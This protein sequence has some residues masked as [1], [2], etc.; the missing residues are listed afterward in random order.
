[1]HYHGLSLRKR[2]ALE[3]ERRLN[4]DLARKHPLRQLFWECTLRCDLKCRHCGSDCKMKSDS[5]D[6]PFEDFARVLESVRRRTDSHNVFITIS[7]GEPLMRADLEECGRRIYDMGFPWGI[8]TN[9]LHLTPDRFRR[10][11]D[12]GIHSMAI[13]LDGLEENHNWMRGHDQSF[14]R[15]EEAIAML[16]EEPLVIYDILTCATERNIHELPALRQWLIDHGVETWRVIDVFPQG[17]AATDPQMLL[18]DEHYRQ[19]LDFIRSSERE[20]PTLSVNYGCE[21]FVGEYE[22]DVRPIA[23][24]CH[25]GIT[26]GGVMADGRIAA[27]A[28]IRSD[29]SQGSIYTDDF[30]DVWESRFQ[31]YRDH[32]W[33]RQGACADCN[34]W[35][36]C[37]GNGMHLRDAEGRLMQCHLERIVKAN[38]PNTSPQP[39]PKGRESN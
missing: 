19:L 34:M 23:F 12:A 26:V 32:S 33:M 3:I 1:M 35:R 15:V 39:S 27:C 10:L 36:Y 14:R 8:V 7:G 25:A 6:M 22:F 28:S 37:Q 11:V 2:A 24:H 9:A 21:G 17:R 30:M 5:H 13:S 16:R 29:Y 18:T 38:S 20:C 31:P 4:A